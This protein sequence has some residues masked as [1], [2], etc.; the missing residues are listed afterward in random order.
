MI[1]TRLLWLAAA[2]LFLYS[3]ALT[4][5]PAVRLHAFAPLNYLHW[6]GYL[7]WLVGFIVSVIMVA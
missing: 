4:L 3:L 1:Q 2:F 7:S 5:A 6:A